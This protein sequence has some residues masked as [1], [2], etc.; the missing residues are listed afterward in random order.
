MT[1][2]KMD[3]LTPKSVAIGGVDGGKEAVLKVSFVANFS[4]Q[5]PAADQSAGQDAR[6]YFTQKLRAWAAELGRAADALES[7]K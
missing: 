4:Q 2:E 1:P 5:S 7:A 6:S 3:A